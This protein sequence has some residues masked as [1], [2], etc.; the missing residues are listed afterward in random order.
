VTQ[1]LHAPGFV[2]SFDFEHLC[3]LEFFE[4]RVREVERNGDTWH[5][6]GR[7]PFGGKPEVRLKHEAA[8]VDFALQLGDPRLEHAF[9]NR[10]AK[11][12]DSE[13]EEFLVGPCGPHVWRDDVASGT[14]GRGVHGHD[15]CGCRSRSV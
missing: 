4:P 14:G 10:D 2:A 9:L 11:L 5:A 7:K 1:D 3:A 8:C 13:V 15:K 12:R 6:V